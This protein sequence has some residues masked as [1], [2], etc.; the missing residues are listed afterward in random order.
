MEEGRLKDNQSTKSDE[1]MSKNMK[2]FL[3]VLNCVMLS[4]GNCIAPLTNRL[5]FVKGGNRTW[6]ACALETA[7]F[8]FLIFPILGSYIYR[9]KYGGPKTRLFFITPDLIIPCVIIGILTGADDYMDSAGVAKLPVSTYSLVLASQLG[10]T[11]FF[12]WI[13]VKQKFTFLHINSIFLL[14]AGAVVLAFHS[15][16]DV[17]DNETKKDYIIGFLMTVGAA[18]LYGFVLPVIELLYKKVKQPITYALVMEMQLVMAF[19]ATAFCMIGMLINHDF[20]AIPREANTYE[21]GKGLYYLVL[22]GDAFLWQLFFL[23]AVG[24]IFCDTSLLSG[25]IIAALLPLSEVLAVF[26]FHEK[27]TIEKGFSLCLALWGFVS[28]FLGEFQENKKQ[29]RDAENT[30]PLDSVEVVSGLN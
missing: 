12:A 15:G 1:K 2:K 25:V 19:S 27:F 20:P 17:P 9:R 23:G 4:I 21:L 28:Y 8:P 10:F 14:T 5:Y 24:V 22:V 7:G 11:A 3:L 26:I 13:L 29:Q 18:I 30:K 6:L 16:S